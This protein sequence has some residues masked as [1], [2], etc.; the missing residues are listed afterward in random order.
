MPRQYP[1]EFKKQVVSF[2]AAGNPL[3]AV[4]EKY[5]LAQST[6]YRWCREYDS[7]GGQSTV[8]DCAAMRRQY[9]RLEHILQI[10]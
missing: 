1:E 8:K 10:I 7:I 3:S 6:I 9:E 4:S 5:Q 2:Y